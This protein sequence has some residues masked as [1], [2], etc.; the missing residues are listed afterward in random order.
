MAQKIL[1]RPNPKVTIDALKRNCA[2]LLQLSKDFRHQI[3]KYAIVSCYERRTVNAV[4]PVVSNLLMDKSAGEVESS[5]DF[6]VV[7]IVDKD[8]ATLNEANEEQIPVDADHQEMCK[9]V[10]SSDTT[11]QAIYIRINRM[12]EGYEKDQRNAQCT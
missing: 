5:D 7:K 6:L 3:A 9:F 4:L 2:F 8:S 10:S 12:V 1:H 11:Y